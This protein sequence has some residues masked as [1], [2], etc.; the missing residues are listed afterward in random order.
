MSGLPDIK[1]L[2]GREDEGSGEEGKIRAREFFWDSI[3]LYVLFAII[4]LTAIDVV[5]EFIR[6]SGVQCFLDGVG[7]NQSLDDLG[8]QDY[9]N[10]FCSGSISMGQY[11]PVFI[12]VHGSLMAIPH[13]LW[14]NH[15]GGNFDTFL[16]LAS[17]LDLLRDETSGEY[18]PKNFVIVDQLST[19]FGTYKRNWMFRV[20]WMKL[21]L[22][23][24]L[25]IAGFVVVIVFFTD[26]NASFD[27]PRTMN[28][29]FDKVWPLSGEQVICIFK[30]LRLIELIRIADLILIVLVI[31]CLSWA[32]LWC[33]ATHPSE[34]GSKNIAK[35]SFI[36]GLPP[37]MYV[38]K[39]DIPCFKSV[40]RALQ[41]IFTTVPMLAP[42]GPR[43]ETDM[44]FLMMKLFRTDGS[45]G[46][47]LKEM[48]ILQLIKGLNNDERRRFNLYAM[49][50][51]FVLTY[52]SLRKG[53]LLSYFEGT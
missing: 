25:A 16:K 34:L 22:Q 37:E 28:D 48:Q 47:I 41:K 2:E 46:G 51:G 4:G 3:V 44:D 32:L 17:K 8:L 19:T 43:I 33:F 14:L 7:L 42:Q 52:G 26:F 20:Y 15:F 21:A 23:L 24:V 39:L 40:R 1:K 11:F 18:M 38:Q 53:L 36:T 12:V 45:L 30:S 31:F 13:Y 9:V 10:D 6:G 29:T 27:C 35:F 49:E 5:A 50:R